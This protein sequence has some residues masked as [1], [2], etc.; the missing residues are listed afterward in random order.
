[1]KAPFKKINVQFNELVNV[2]VLSDVH[3]GAKYCNKSAL[4]KAIER[5]KTQNSRVIILGDFFDLILPKDIKRYD[6][7]QIDPEIVNDP[8]PVN[9]IVD[10]A[11]E[12]LSEIK[13]NIDVMITGNHEWEV[14]KRHGVNPI[15]MLL[16]SLYGRDRED[17]APAYHFGYDGFFR[18]ILEEPNGMSGAWDIYTRHGSTGAAP[19]TEGMLE[20]KR[21]M[22]AYHA[23]IYLA[24]HNHCTN[25]F[26]NRVVGVSQSGYMFTKQ[27]YALRCGTFLDSEIEHGAKG[28]SYPK[29]GGFAFPVIGAAQFQLGISR[30]KGK[31]EKTTNISMGGTI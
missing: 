12:Y 13:E 16:D 14:Q 4:R 22:M 17:G 5:A 21:T 2:C 19:M 23:D 26:T 1:V 10:M 15:M 11:C 9:T 8:Q 18:Y 7:S 28:I 20:I 3:L 30:N 6:P 27:V 25:S 24:G 29:K 31:L